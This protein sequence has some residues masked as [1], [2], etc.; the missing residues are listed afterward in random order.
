M[1]VLGTGHA[2]LV[3]AAVLGVTHGF[4]PDHAAGISVLT[5]GADDRTHAAFVG[6]S[7]AV[8][9]VVVVLAWVAVLS[10]LGRGASAAPAALS[11]LG[12]VI[13]GVVLAAAG[14][15]LA[16]RG[17]RRLRGDEPGRFAAA[18]G[19]RTGGAVAGLLGLARGHVHHRHD[20]ASAYLRTGI[21]GSLFALSPPVSMLALVSTVVP[22]AG[23]EGAVGAVA[24]YAVAITL[25]MA[26]VGAGIGEVF[27]LVRG[28]GRRVHAVLEL[29]TSA[30]VCW[31]AAH[32]LL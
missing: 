8:G 4:E 28:H 32:L 11:T 25:T 27:A 24:V 20:S 10:L 26:A 9:H 22:T 29:A 6:G 13:P 30:F 2:L 7:F 12:T 1:D 15:L 21:V 14:L 18:D 19:G 23:A 3:T 17:V 31:F 5:D 16:A